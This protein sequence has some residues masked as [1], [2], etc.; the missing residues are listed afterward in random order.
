MSTWNY[1]HKQVM[2]QW[3]F[4]LVVPWWE[5]HN[6]KFVFFQ[7]HWILLLFVVFQAAMLTFSSGIVTVIML[8]EELMIGQ[9]V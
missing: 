5:I 6:G 4:E 8:E 9:K 7:K 1:L 3:L 2:N